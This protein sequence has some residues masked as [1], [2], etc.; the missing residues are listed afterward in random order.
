MLVVSI[1]WV[2]VVV[3]FALA[4]AAAHDGTWLGALVTLALG[5]SPL[6]VVLYIVLM[7]SRRRRARRASA[8]DPDRSGHASGD[9]IAAKREEP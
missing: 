9:A 5:L 4:Q 6:A 2:F 3:V 7:A 1:G 8:T